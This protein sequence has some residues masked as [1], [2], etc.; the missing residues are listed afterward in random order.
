[1]WMAIRSI[2]D[3]EISRYGIAPKDLETVEKRI[4]GIERKQI[5]GI[6]MRKKCM[7]LM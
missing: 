3:K 1:M 2:S 5:Q 7:I 4:G 6:K